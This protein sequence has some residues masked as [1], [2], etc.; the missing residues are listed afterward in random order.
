MACDV[1]V[2]SFEVKIEGGCHLGSPCV[3]ENNVFKALCGCS[4]QR[5]LWGEGAA[6]VEMR[7]IFNLGFIFGLI[8]LGSSHWIC[9]RMST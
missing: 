3:V 8:R 7:H 6:M 4:K 1:L 5:F 9:S 2:D